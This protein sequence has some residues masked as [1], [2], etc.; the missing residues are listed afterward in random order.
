VKLCPACGHLE[1]APCGIVDCPLVL[2]LDWDG[3]P[4]VVLRYV[5][6]DRWLT[7]EDWYEAMCSVMADR[8]PA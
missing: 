6:D 1:L 3:F 4:E 5:W 7:P 8:A 2:E